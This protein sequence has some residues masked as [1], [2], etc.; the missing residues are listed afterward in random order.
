[1][2][3]DPTCPLCGH[4]RKDSTYFLFHYTKASTTWCAINAGKRGRI[5]Y[6][7]HLKDWLDE[8]LHNKTRCCIS[9]LPW[10]VVFVA[11]FWHIWKDRNNMAFND[12]SLPT[13]VLIRKIYYHTSE[14]NHIFIFAPPL[15]KWYPLMASFKLN[16]DSC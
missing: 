15:I 12:N 16:I 9:N 7:S 2:L 5:P 11:G 3:T 4:W 13:N 6:C 14:I 10:N 1:M 8:N